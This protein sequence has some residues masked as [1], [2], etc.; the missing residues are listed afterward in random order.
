LKAKMIKC[1][2]IFSTTLV[3]VTMLKVKPLKVR[4][5]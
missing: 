4:Y 1:G 3:L 5:L 2:V